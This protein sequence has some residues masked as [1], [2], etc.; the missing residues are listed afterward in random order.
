[1]GIIGVN[2]IN[3]EGH[4]AAMKNNQNSLT[5]DGTGL[6]NAAN[7]LSNLWVGSSKDIFSETIAQLWQ[8][9]QALIVD[10]GGMIQEV[11]NVLDGFELIDH[12]GR[13]YFKLY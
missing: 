13:N 9:I 10:L 1:M 2:R 7:G 12:T 6:Y 8:D 11:Q 4:L 5:T 3:L